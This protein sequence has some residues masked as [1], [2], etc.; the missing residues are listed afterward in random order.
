MS[1]AFI[2]VCLCMPIKPFPRQ[3]DI[4]EDNATLVPL[5]D[6]S[7]NRSWYTYACPQ[8]TQDFNW[9]IKCVF[10]ID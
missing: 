4:Y 2:L 6:Q 5:I 7:Q 9:I 1:A 8:E 3:A 10:F